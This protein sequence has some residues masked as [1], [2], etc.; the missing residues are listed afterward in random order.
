M[1]TTRTTGCGRGSARWQ[2]VP[3]RVL[4]IAETRVRGYAACTA[5]S[6]WGVWCAWLGRVTRYRCYS[7]R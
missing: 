1:L 3:G 5:T 7:E 2:M 4:R 6:S